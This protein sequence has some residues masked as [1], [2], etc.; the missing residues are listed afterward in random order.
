[1]MQQGR[2]SSRLVLRLKLLEASSNK[3]GE[4]ASWK[5]SWRI[6]RLI[7]PTHG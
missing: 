2:L 6:N 5:D 4:S 7:S 3:N 1:M